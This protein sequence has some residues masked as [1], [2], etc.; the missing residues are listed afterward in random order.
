[1]SNDVRIKVTVDNTSAP[2]L[3]SVSERLK[4]VEE[5]AKSADRGIGAFDRQLA[6]LDASVEASKV[7]LGGLRRAFAD[8]DD[9]AQRMDIGKVMRKVESDIRTATRSKK[10]LLEEMLQPEQALKRVDT[11]GNEVD[12]AVA[13]GMKLG[14]PQLIAAAVGLGVLMAPAIGS[15]IGGAVLGAVG[16][17]GVIGG[18]ALAAQDPRVKDAGSFM[19]KSIGDQLKDAAK[20]FIPATLGAI[21]TVIIA[22]E[23][24]QTSF[25]NIFANAAQ[26]VKPLTD[27]IMGMVKNIMPGIQQ[28]MASAAPVIKMIA[29]ELPQV[30]AAFSHMFSMI[31]SDSAAAT[32]GLKFVFDAIEG[33]VEFVGQ[34]IAAMEWLFRAT[35][36]VDNALLDMTQVLFSFVG[37]NPF[38]GLHKSVIGLLATMDA[39]GVSSASVASG[40]DTATTAADAERSANERLTASLNAAVQ[41][42]ADLFDAQINVGAAMDAATKAAEKNGRATSDNTEKGR[43]NNTALSSLAKSFNQMTY[44]MEK[45]GD[46]ASKVNRTFED[47][48]NKLIAMAEKMGY[49]HGKAVELADSLLKIPVARETKIKADTVAASANLQRLQSQL[50]ALHDKTITISARVGQSFGYAVN[51][52]GNEISDGHADSMSAFRYTGGV[53]GGAAS[54][55]ARS[56]MTWVG[57]RGPELMRLPA[58]TTVH[59]A[60]DSQRMMD[61]SGSG[62]GT[63]VLEIHSGGS[64]LDDLLVEILQTAV[65]ARGGNVQ[66]VIGQG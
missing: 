16:G 36:Q 61:S 42:S 51:A 26:Y 38:E 23:G 41:G 59:S 3:A 1:M 15:A 54:G 62:G 13:N 8:A 45:N 64:R 32:A 27:G 47:Q 7:Q 43:A 66:T 31:S 25:K 46:A 21:N 65:R 4:A 52:V 56:G 10:G 20:P 37:L 9:A 58:G 30:G 44:D 63:T 6:A 5:S 11:F 12:A 17:A 18:I 29:D 28:A 34:L 14:Q 33:G 60:G 57:E 49:A 50:N 48:R 35:L 2:G 22:F 19:A 40:M 24:M 55:G 39:A 53:I